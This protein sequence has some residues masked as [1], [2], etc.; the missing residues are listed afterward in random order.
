MHL[1]VLGEVGNVE[2]A[3]PYK[4]DVSVRQVNN[5]AGLRDIRDTV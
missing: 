3:F 1:V 5:E 2:L 4:L